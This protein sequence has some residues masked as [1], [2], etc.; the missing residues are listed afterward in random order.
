M[1]CS[2]LSL[3]RGCGAQVGGACLSAIIF[4][5]VA[6]VIN[7]SDA[8]SS[9]YEQQLDRINEFIRFHRLPPPIR[10]K[11]HGYHDRTLTCAAI[12]SNRSEATHNTSEATHNTSSRVAMLGHAARCS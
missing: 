2:A 3:A 12:E 10:D 5:N 11:L 9:R 4:S 1:T 7:K 8:A 6:Q